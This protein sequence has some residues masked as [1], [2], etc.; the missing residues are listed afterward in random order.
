MIEAQDLL[1][2]RKIVAL[3]KITK[4]Y[5]IAL[6]G[7][8]TI[9]NSLLGGCYFIPFMFSIGMYRC[10]YIILINDVKFVKHFDLL[11]EKRLINALLS[12]SK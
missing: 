11:P 8:E 3:T 9:S 12:G 5:I 1:F 2:S 6:Y 10:F 4:Q 7:Y